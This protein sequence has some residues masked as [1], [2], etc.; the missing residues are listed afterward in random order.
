VS[1]RKRLFRRAV[2]P[3]TAG[4]IIGLTLALMAGPALANVAVRVVSRDLFTNTDAY[5]STEVEPDTFAWGDTIVSAFQVGRYSDGGADDVGFA[6]STNRGQNWTRGILPSLTVWSSP[7]GP[8]K[9]ATDPAVAYDAKHD[10][11]MIMTL[12]SNASFGFNGDAVTVSRS[13]DGGLTFGAPVTVTTAGI[14][15]DKT[16]ISCDNWPSSPFFGNCYGEWDDFGAGATLKLMRSTD[17]GLTWTNSTAPSTGTIG[18]FPV[19]LPNGTVVVPIDS[20]PISSVMSFVS[21]NGGASYTGPVTISNF[22]WH[23]V[24]GSFRSLPIPTAGVDASGKVYVV[25][26]DCRFRSG[27]S[28]NDLVMSTSTNGTTWSAVTRIPID[29]T[30]SGEDHFVPGLGVDP[31]A[32]GRLGLLYYHYPVAN[33]SEATCNLTV[34]FISS[35][36]GGATWGTPRQLFGP[37]KVTGLPL[38]S[39]GYMA[40]DYNS[41][42]YIAGRARTVFAVAGTT[43]CTLGQITSCKVVMVAPRQGLAITGGSRP[44]VTGPV[45]WTGGNTNGGL[46]SSR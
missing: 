42:D 23:S 10:V 24:N 28:A 20:N 33:C 30:N 41:V 34:D 2:R 8:Y 29:P 6:T 22:S 32:N 12:D 15:L 9:R 18:G 11:W 1:S 19:A 31:S 17:G 40:S 43:N 44:A 4:L 36:D 14:S 46:Q 26:H 39:S 7:P 5:H 21:T 45:L 13:T 16:W 27:C 25:W 35:T 38:T 3:A 37:M